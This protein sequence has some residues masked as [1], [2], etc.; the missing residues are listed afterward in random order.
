MLKWIALQVISLWLSSL[1]RQEHL[2]IGMCE[3]FSKQFK[4]SL[5]FAAVKLYM[6]M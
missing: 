1:V 2:N 3:F 5:L 6:R 4:P